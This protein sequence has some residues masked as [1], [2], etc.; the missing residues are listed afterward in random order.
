[1]ST[2]VLVDV[3]LEESDELLEVAEEDAAVK[4]NG[5][6]LLRLPTYQ[7]RL[8][9]LVDE[10]LDSGDG[11][12]EDGQVLQILLYAT[13]F[14]LAV[15]HQT[16]LLE[17]AALLSVLLALLEAARQRSPKDPL[18][19]R[20]IRTIL[21]TANLLPAATLLIFSKT[22][23]LIAICG[24]LLIVLEFALLILFPITILFLIIT[25]FR[26]LV[27]SLVPAE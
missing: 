2:F 5:A 13:L 15:D 16:H 17:M 24:L 10:G 11:A 6:Q 14:I 18:C 25:T 12:G 19:R 21:Q 9:V 22:R 20:T 4:A 1:M 26:R 8:V 23:L 3:G 7:D 27:M